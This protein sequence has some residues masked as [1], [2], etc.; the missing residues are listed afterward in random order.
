MGCRIVR[1][2]DIKIDFPNKKEK[3]SSA[4]YNMFVSKVFNILPF[5]MNIVGVFLIYYMMKLL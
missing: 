4:I 5:V 2:L 3:V 1:N